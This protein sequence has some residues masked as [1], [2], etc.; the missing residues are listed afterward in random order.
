MSGR[1]E[2][3]LKPMY[4]KYLGQWRGTSELGTYCIA[5]IAWRRSR[6]QGTVG[7]YEAIEIEGKLEPYWATSY[8]EATETSNGKLEGRLWHSAIYD[9]NGVPLTP[10][11]LEF[12]KDKVPDFEMPAETSFT[13]ALT[14]ENKLEI[15]WDSKF[16]SGAERREH[17]DLLRSAHTGSTIKSKPMSW[18]DFREFALEQDD[19]WIYR[20]QSNHRRLQTTFHRAGGADMIDYLDNEVMDLERHLNVYSS[21]LY[22]ATNDRS[23]G[24]LLNLAQ[25]HGYPTP[26][27]DWTRS[28]YVAAF[29]AFENERSVD[30]EGNVSI[31]MFNEGEWVDRVGRFAQ[32]RTPK[33]QLRALELP[34]YGNPRALPQQSVTMY[35][36]ADDIAALIKENEQTDGE[37]L[38]AIVI[39]GSDREIAMRDLQLMGVTWQSMFPG[40]DGVCK[41]LRAKHFGH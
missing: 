33:P 40:L 6:L 8:F 17:V 30:R 5:N 4:R 25:H 15:D 36:N 39:P 10:Q 32:M 12:I 38:R 24:G 3:G 22:D 35:C 19:G 16:T 37:F 28:P 11:Q 20:G 2:T 21:H 18:N 26:L 7:V 13:G 31:F 14:E 9:Q 23:L 1:E 29:F 34:G 41:H 27:L